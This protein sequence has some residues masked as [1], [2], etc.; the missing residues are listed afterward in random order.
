MRWKPPRSW[1][2][3]TCARSSRATQN[4]IPGR[5]ASMRVQGS[6]NSVNLFDLLLD[7]GAVGR[8]GWCVNFPRC[9]CRHE[10]DSYVAC[11]DCF[12][13]SDDVC[14]IAA[15]VNERHPSCV[16]VRF[17]LGIVTFIIRQ[18][19][20]CDDDQAVTRVGVPA[21]GSYDVCR[22]VDRLPPP[23][24]RRHLSAEDARTQSVTS[25]ATFKP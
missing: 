20:R 17:A 16:H 19:P 9:T 8:R 18:S 21:R 25:M 10:L 6:N 24:S 23:G 4:G 12:F 2:R 7:A 3:A 11:R 14:V 13:V 1:R 5:A 15:G 22:W